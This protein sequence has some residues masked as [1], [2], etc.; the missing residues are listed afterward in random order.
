MA[1]LQAQMLTLEGLKSSQGETALETLSLLLIE[2]YHTLK[3]LKDDSHQLFDLDRWWHPKANHVHLR[4]TIQAAITA[5]G[6]VRGIPQKH[7]LPLV[8]Y[9]YELSMMHKSYDHLYQEKAISKLKT[10][11]V[12]V[13]S[14]LNKLYAQ[15]LKKARNDC[16]TIEALLR[17]TS[18]AS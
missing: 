8:N 1:Q 3:Y 10:N 18:S 9:N 12:Q 5:I 16:T 6:Q 11:H 4:D 14:F 15:T 7:A 2:I 13:L 17:N